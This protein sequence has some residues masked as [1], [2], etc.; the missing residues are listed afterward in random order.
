MNDG[1]VQVINSFHRA[2]NNGSLMT[3]FYDIFLKK[4]PELPSL[5]A[6]TDFVRQVR[7]LRQSLLELL[8][9]AT[10]I[11]SA[12]A[13]MTR[14]KEMH[15]ELDIKPVHFK[16]WLDALCEAVAV[17]DPKFTPELET[18][19]RQALQPGIDAMTSDSP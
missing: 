8:N 7:M 1:L 10:G 13:E 19:W 11:E 9:Y 12:V 2:R 4:S 6:R 5:F 16:L 15:A 17:H 14:L 18:L 3:T